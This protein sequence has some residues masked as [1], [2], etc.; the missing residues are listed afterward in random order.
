MCASSTK[1]DYTELTNFKANKQFRR[2]WSRDG[3]QLVFER[4]M[5]INDAILLSDFK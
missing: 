3:K 4:G 2:T 1:P 5:E